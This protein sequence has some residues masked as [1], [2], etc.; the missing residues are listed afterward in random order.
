[1]S[2]RLWSFFLSPFCSFFLQLLP[3]GL[4]F[5]SY[6]ER[7]KYLVVRLTAGIALS[8]FLAALDVKLGWNRIPGYFLFSFILV[9]MFVLGIICLC[10]QV[11]PTD[12]VFV[13]MGMYVAQHMAFL[14]AN[15]LDFCLSQ[16]ALQTHPVWLEC[17]CTGGM[18]AACVLAYLPFRACFHKNVNIKIK[19]GEIVSIALCLFLVIYLL[20]YLLRGYEGITV[21]YFNVFDCISCVFGMTIIYLEFVKNTAQWEKQVIEQILENE[22]ARYRMSQNSAARI[23]QRCHDLKYMIQVLRE[24]E[25]GSARDTYI[26]QMEAEVLG[27]ERIAKTGSDVLDNVLTE[28]GL[29][30]GENQISFTYIAD[31]EKLRFMEDVDI[32]VLFGNALDNAIECVMKY[33]DTEKRL[34]RL[35]IVGKGRLVHIRLGNYCE[36]TVRFRNG[37]PVTTKADA[38]AHGFGVQSISY[39]AE[40]YDGYV[41]F[42]QKGQEVVLNIVLQDAAKGSSEEE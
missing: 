17:I 22:R 9:L 14:V 10:F 4:L 28:K 35:H 15:M 21:F 2:E 26:N 7:R 29:Y 34:I 27:Y 11:C 18:V 41:R 3:I 25:G 20:R 23:N 13:G 12:F 31:G 40:K 5:S 16:T 36:E 38:A 33:S 19:N 37:L 6:L 39:I 1:M 32:A 8:L 42:V 24:Q 30:C